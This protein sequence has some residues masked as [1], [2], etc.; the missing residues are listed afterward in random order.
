MTSVEPQGIGKQSLA[1]A[2]GTRTA[3]AGKLPP[4]P[5]ARRQETV[6]DVRERPAEPEEAPK[7]A[8][9][10]SEAEKR[11]EASRKE[12]PARKTRAVKAD[13]PTASKTQIIVYLPV[14]LAE[15]LRAAGEQSGRT[16]LQLVTDALDATHERL[17]DLLAAAGYVES[18][19]SGLFSKSAQPVSRRPGRRGT[20]QISLRP[21]VDV[22]DV[23]DRLVEKH[24]APNRSALIEVALDAHLPAV[25]SR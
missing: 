10:A 9:A 2:F 20:A 13:K 17:D 1:G 15:R 11:T 23:M 25:T 6:V 21:P 19:T 5:G 18:R 24:S 4:R 12:A 8:E 3:G 14:D 16:H 7:A 22:R